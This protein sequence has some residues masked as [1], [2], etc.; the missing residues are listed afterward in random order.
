VSARDRERFLRAVLPAYVKAEQALHSGDVTPRLST[1]SQRD[2]V[3][4]F[5]AGVAYR[6]GWTD[7]RGVFDWLATTFTGCDDFDVELL[8]ADVSRD[9]GYT[10]GIERYHARTSSGS[11]VQN[12]LRVT[13]V[14]RRQP[15]G[16]RIVHR[17][18][19][20]MVADS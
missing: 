14:F 9:L 8:A 12:T 20:H 19:D 11:E 2:P 17:H 13:H 18:G 1:W 4:L 6:S 16:W 10:V 7:V 3:T 15:D 5:G